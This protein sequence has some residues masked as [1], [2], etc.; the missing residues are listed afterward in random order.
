[1]NV[2]YLLRKIIIFKIL[3]NISFK[4]NYKCIIYIYTFTVYDTPVYKNVDINFN[5]F[6]GN[7][8]L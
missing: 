1:M 8:V 5:K 6:D 2:I 4:I 3:Y 7:M